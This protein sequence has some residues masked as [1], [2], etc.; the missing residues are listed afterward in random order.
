MEFKQS[1]AKLEYDV[2]D[3]S[4]IKKTFKAYSYIGKK[5]MGGKKMDLLM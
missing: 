3:E 4:Y 5:I 2:W 1:S